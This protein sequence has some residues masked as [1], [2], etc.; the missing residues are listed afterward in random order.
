MG[1]PPTGEG[2]HQHHAAAVRH[3]LRQG[4]DLIRSLNDLQTVPQPLHHGSCIEQAALKA[5]GG[6]AVSIGPAEGAE[7]SSVGA[8]DAVAGV[9]HQKGSSAVGAFGFAGLQ[10]ELTK[11][12]GLLIT[13]KGLNWQ[14]AEGEFRC[15]ASELSSAGQQ[16]R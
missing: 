9:D 8:A 16:F 7:Q 10:T 5:V 6:R 13:E 14:S 11:G 12:R 2:R 3:R 4:V 1:S 15:D